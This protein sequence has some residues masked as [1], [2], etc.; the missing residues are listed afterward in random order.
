MN[1]GA[2][3]MNLVLGKD[4]KRISQFRSATLL[5]MFTWY[6]AFFLRFFLPFSNFISRLC[7]IILLFSAQVPENQFCP[8]LMLIQ[9]HHCFCYFFVR[10]LSTLLLVSSPISLKAVERALATGVVDRT[11][12]EQPSIN[13]WA[14]RRPRPLPSHCSND[15]LVKWMV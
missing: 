15:E 3:A 13:E 6:L 2:L 5:P 12:L 1:T 8:F 7:L 11:G 9:N 4:S 10:F 14:V